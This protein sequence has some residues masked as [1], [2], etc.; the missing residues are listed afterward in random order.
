MKNSSA[1]LVNL[2]LICE[3]QG[4]FYDKFQIG[5]ALIGLAGSK[6]IENGNF[7]DFKCL[8]NFL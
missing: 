1:Y 5:L 7:L 6:F 3:A 2:K 8:N 4:V